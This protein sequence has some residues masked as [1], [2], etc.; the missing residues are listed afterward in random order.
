MQQ[1]RL[2]I[3]D[4]HANIT[5]KGPDI[6]FS[7]ILLSGIG[8]FN[9]GFV[10]LKLKDKNVA[11]ARIFP[12]V[13]KEKHK[14]ELNWLLSNDILEPI[15]FIEWVTLILPVLKKDGS[16]RICGDF[17]VTI[18]PFFEIDKF[19]LNRIEELF[20]KLQSGVFKNIFVANL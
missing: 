7:E 10:L 14:N 18:N 1:F 2:N 13:I 11:R 8:T 4:V 16:V 15:D 9:R 6:F 17:K 3:A 19:L 5:I 12:Y 20:W